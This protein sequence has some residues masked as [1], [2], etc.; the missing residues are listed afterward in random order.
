MGLDGI[1]I[2]NMPLDEHGSMDI[3]PALGIYGVLAVGLYFFV[4]NMNRFYEAQKNSK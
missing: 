2:K 3:M 4:D 1:F